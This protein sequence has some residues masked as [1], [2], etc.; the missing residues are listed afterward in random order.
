[1][2]SNTNKR[3]KQKKERWRASK[4]TTYGHKCAKMKAMKQTEGRVDV[5]LKWIKTVQLCGLCYW[6]WLKTPSSS[7]ACHMPAACVLVC[8]I[9]DKFI[10]Q[11]TSSVPR[12]HFRI[13]LPE[14]YKKNTSNHYIIVFIR[15]T[16]SSTAVITSDIAK[17]D[18]YVLLFLF[19][20]SNAVFMLTII[21]MLILS[22]FS[23]IQFLFSLYECYFRIY[24]F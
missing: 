19:W 6:P 9:T 4:K 22:V 5:K 8:T 16:H 11:S 23:S 2:L 20:P 21:T 18:F 17:L 15:H 10:N 13:N 3:P 14:T 7:I 24:F 12:A 1:M